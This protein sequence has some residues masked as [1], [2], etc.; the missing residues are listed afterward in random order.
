VINS[1]RMTKGT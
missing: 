1:K